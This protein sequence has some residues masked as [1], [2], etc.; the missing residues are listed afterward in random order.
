MLFR[1]ERFLSELRA[2]KIV[3]KV[4]R[5]KVD[6]YGSLSLTGK[7][8]AT[9]LAIMLGLSG[10]D[11]EYIPV[12]NIAGIVETIKSKKEIEE[13][14]GIPKLNDHESL[15]LVKPKDQAQQ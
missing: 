6:L 9:D 10:Q 7:G 2:E 1:S 3:P 12:Q 11:P 15:K 8:H 14:E 5:I 13:I 4:T